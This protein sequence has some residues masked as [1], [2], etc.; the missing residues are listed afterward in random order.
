MRGQE[1]QLLRNFGWWVFDFFFLIT[2]GSGHLKRIG[3]KTLKELVGVTKKL[4]KNR[5]F[6]RR[7]LTDSYIFEN[8]G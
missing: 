5:Q 6:Y 4:A 3:I 1:Y 2:L 8:H 7:H